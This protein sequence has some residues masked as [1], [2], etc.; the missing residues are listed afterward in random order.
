MA[1]FGYPNNTYVGMRYVP[2]FDG[3]WVNSKDYEP[4][5]VVQYNNNS[6]TSKTFV[7]AGVV[8]QGNEKYW[9]E[10]GN[11]N[12]Q[13]EQYRNEVLTYEKSVEDEVKNRKDADIAINERIDNLSVKKMVM[14]GDSYG[15]QN[16]GTVIKFFWEYFRDSLYLV[17]NET[18]FKSFK[19]GAGFGNG[20]F[21]SQLQSLNI[22]EKDTITDIFVCGGWNDSD[23]SQPYGTDEAFNTGV[24][25]FNAYVKGNYKNAKITLAHISWANG[26]KK[27]AVY[28][29]MKVSIERYNRQGEKGWRVLTG[30]EYILHR[31]E[32]GI[33]QTSDYAHPGQMGQ[34]YLGIYLPTAFL[35]GS[36]NV[37][38]FGSD[39]PI[40]K[41]GDFIINSPVTSKEM[42]LNGIY[43]LDYSEQVT[44]NAPSGKTIKTD[45]S[46]EYPLYGSDYTLGLVKN[47]STCLAVPCRLYENG[48]TNWHNAVAFLN[49][50]NNITYAR[51]SVI[52]LNTAISEL[53]VKYIV[54]PS[55][56]VTI[57]FIN[58]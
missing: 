38:Y 7:P 6:Y 34:G 8:P 25:D 11:Y 51:F 30:C 28:E 19:S 45:T 10:T 52:D 41:A 22:S 1:D 21:L 54:M 16:D 18:F 35:N 42:F 4:L 57:P 53:T 12:A 15:I 49:I 24:S 9:A 58:C 50:H 13:I 36:C 3:E 39:H 56:H 20:E 26:E 5:V 47:N 43:S 40:V 37:Q 29:Q 31:Y 55:L 46:E 14:I 17:E 27:P 44:L 23:K 32:D 48:N 2:L 33:W